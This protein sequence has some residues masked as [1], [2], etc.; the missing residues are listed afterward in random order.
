MSDTDD[1]ISGGGDCVVALEAT[2]GEIVRSKVPLEN[3]TPIGLTGCSGKSLSGH[4]SSWALTL[5]IVSMRR[6]GSNE[7]IDQ[8]QSF[9]IS[10]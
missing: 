4:G 5:E 6:Q 8:S 2:F 7:R 9:Y 3:T 10:E 1:P